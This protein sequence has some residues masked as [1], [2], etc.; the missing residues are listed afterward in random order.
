MSLVG[1]RAGA[2]ATADTRDD[3]EARL[4][5]AIKTLREARGWSQTGLAGALRARGHSLNQ[6]QVAKTENGTRSLSVNEAADFA[7]VLGVSL[8]DL[9]RGRPTLGQ[10]EGDDDLATAARRVRELELAV[11]SCKALV[12]QQAAEYDRL[13]GQ[14]AAAA[15]QKDLVERQYE[16]LRM[17]LE[18]AR[19]DYLRQMREGVP[20]DG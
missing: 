6:S 8:V 12:R 7:A 20:D 3:P 18:A 17:E 2:G 4:G 1:T 10:E 16:A 13:Q 9:L 5:R 15:D 11:S 19:L 14:V